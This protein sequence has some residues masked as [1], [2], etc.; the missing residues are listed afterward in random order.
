VAIPGA[1]NTT[2]VTAA[3]ADADV[4]T[5]EVAGTGSC[6][7]SSFNSI[8]MSVSSGVSSVATTAL[9]VRVTPN[10]NK[11]EFAIKGSLGVNIDEE[12]TLEVTDMLGRAIYTGTSHTRG[13]EISELIALDNKLTNGVYL[14][15]VRTAAGANKVFHIVV[16]R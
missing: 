7:M 16:E 11:G 4:F 5:C 10:P 3:I 12:I 1:T 14:L 6:E 8:V 13:G 9:D 15:N 2:Y